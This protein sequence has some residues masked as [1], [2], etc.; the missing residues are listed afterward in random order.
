MPISVRDGGTWKEAA[1]HVRD[2]GTWKAVQRAYVRDAGTWK[3][4]YKASEVISVTIGSHTTKV[5]SY[6]GYNSSATYTPNVAFGSAS[7]TTV[8]GQTIR[9]MF[10]SIGVVF[11]IRLDG[12]L[13]QDFFS[14]VNVVGTDNNVYTY[15]TS[16]LNS[17]TAGTYT[18][19]SWLDSAR[20]TS[21]TRNVTFNF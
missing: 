15:N 17:Y 6:Y 19:W 21:G 4:F 18:E 5:G 16:S 10:Y 2:A 3:E 8:N 13:S 20:W 1:M 9:S 7:P 12:S 11:L 14:T